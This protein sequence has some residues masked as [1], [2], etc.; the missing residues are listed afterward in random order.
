VRRSLGTVLGVL[1]AWWLLTDGLH[2]VVPGF[3]PGPAATWA[4]FVDGLRNGS[5]GANVG[6]SLGRLLLGY[7]VG[8]AL[9]L[10]VGVAVGISRS[11]G[12]FLQPLLNFFSNL[13]GIVWLPI[14]ITWFG[15][16][17]LTVTF[18]LVNSVFF[19]VA[20]NTLTGIQSVPLTYEHAVAVLGARRWRIVAQ[21]LIPGAFPGILSGLR[22]AMAFGWR[23]LIVAEMAASAVGLG[24]MV[25]SASGE[26]RP[27]VILM[28]ILLIGV[29]ATVLDQLVFAPL[30]RRVLSRWGLARSVLES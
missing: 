19:V 25:Y 2:L 10:A 1:L 26:S 28:G 9:G 7:A 11:V 3:L 18:I 22:L 17:W 6:A 27:D 8:S 5:L 4:A 12:S 30:E 23:A 24:Y 21:V 15:L 29:V 16:G 20:A 14:A 13:A